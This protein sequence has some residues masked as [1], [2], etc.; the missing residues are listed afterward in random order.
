[1]KKSI[2]ILLAGVALLSVSA[3]CRPEIMGSVKNRL[4]PQE[5]NNWCW[6]AT[7]QMLGQHFDIGVDQCDLAN[8][9]FSDSDCCDPENPEESCPKNNECNRPGWLELDFIGL[10]FSESG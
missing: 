3:C 6:A 7:T 4:R 8:H 10:K 2:S 9:V 1:M 5:T